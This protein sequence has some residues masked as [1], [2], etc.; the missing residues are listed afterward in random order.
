MTPR[1]TFTKLML[2][3]T[4]HSRGK[5]Q[6]QQQ[7]PGFHH[8]LLPLPSPQEVLQQEMKELEGRVS[9]IQQVLGDLKVKLYA[10]FGNNINLEADESWA[11]KWTLTALS[12]WTFFLSC[13]SYFGSQWTVLIYVYTHTQSNVK[14]V[15]VLEPNLETG[16]V[17]EKYNKWKW[18]KILLGHS[19]FHTFVWLRVTTCM[20]NIHPAPPP[21][22]QAIEFPWVNVNMY[23]KPSSFAATGMNTMEIFTFKQEN[24]LSFV[25]ENI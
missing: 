25:L 10:K 7:Q 24:R 4:W 8:C 12:T 6:Q 9:A 14:L 2:L 21:H 18:C 1:V 22:S 23:N 19:I 20:I 5:Q 17:T 13:G 3:L 15:L 16:Q 11:G